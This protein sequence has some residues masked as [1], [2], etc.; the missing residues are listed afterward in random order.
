MLPVLVVLTVYEACSLAPALYLTAQQLEHQI[1]R[2]EP[3]SRLHFLVHLC[4]PLKLT[5]LERMVLNVLIISCVH[6]QEGCQS[7]VDAVGA[8]G[9]TRLGQAVLDVAVRLRSPCL[10]PR[11]WFLYLLDWTPPR[12]C[13]LC[14]LE[15][16]RMQ[17]LQ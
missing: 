13:R 5:M 11:S 15:V 3:L 1:R 8:N 4:A 6:V 17:F 10:E 7:I 14:A 9:L 2:L 12:A 16:T